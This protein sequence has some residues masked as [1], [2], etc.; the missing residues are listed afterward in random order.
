[1][2]AEHQYSPPGPGTHLGAVRLAVRDIDR[3]ADFY[4]RAIGLEPLP[5]DGPVMRLGAGGRAIVELESAPDADGALADP[6]G[7]RVVITAC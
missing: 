5:S 2:P 3:S 1:M 6:A 4:A 7:N